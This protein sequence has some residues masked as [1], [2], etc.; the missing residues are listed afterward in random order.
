MNGELE[1]PNAIKEEEI[2]GMLGKY[3]DAFVSSLS[4]ND[5]ILYLELIK[6]FETDEKKNKRNLSLSSFMENLERIYAFVH[7]GDGYD[8]FRGFVCGIEFGNQYIL[9]NS[10]RLT[11]LMHKSKSCIN[12]CLQK[13]GFVLLR[14]QQDISGFFCAVIP[15]MTS[16]ICN[17]RQWCMR[18]SPKDNDKFQSYIPDDI[19]Q[20]YS[21]C[22]PREKTMK[23]LEISFLLNPPKTG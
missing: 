4:M 8:I 20:K 21:I 10:K 7:K 9:V 14:Q 6:S 15:G 19:A 2:R 23:S 1:R 17:S 11:T 12:N 13:L 5:Q 22:T 16:L 3:M 18:I